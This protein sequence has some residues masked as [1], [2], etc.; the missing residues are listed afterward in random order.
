MPRRRD[1]LT[2]STCSVNKD[3]RGVRTS[4]HL[5]N[6]SVWC[7]RRNS[8]SAFGRFNMGSWYWVLIAALVVVIIV[9]WIVRQ[10]QQR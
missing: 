6:D 4:P 5:D 7:R 10:R 9:L 8:P 2:R 1:A 3:A